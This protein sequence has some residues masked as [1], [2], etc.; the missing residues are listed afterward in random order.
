MATVTKKELIDTIAERQKIRR[1]LVKDTVK[2]FLE[3]IVER[4]A[5]GDRIEFR[6]FGVFEVRE[7]AP[8]TAQNPKTLQRVYVPAKRSIKF[9]PGRLLRDKLDPA[10]A[11]PQAEA[12]PS[13][14]VT[15]RPAGIAG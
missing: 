8:R 11:A 7:R 15:Q 12:P 3:L 14:V 13:V 2:E 10:G 9:K 4:L 5:A 6:E 1:G